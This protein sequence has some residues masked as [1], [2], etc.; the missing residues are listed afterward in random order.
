MTFSLLLF[1]RQYLNLLLFYQGFAWSTS[2]RIES[3]PEKEETDPDKLVLTRQEDEQ[4]RPATTPDSVD[5][6]YFWR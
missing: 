1:L 4:I 6:F 2:I 5:S 3:S